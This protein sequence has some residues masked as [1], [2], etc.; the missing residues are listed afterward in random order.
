MWPSPGLDVDHDNLGSYHD[1]QGR[2][3]YPMLSFVPHG[4]HLPYNFT[5]P[6]PANVGISPLTQFYDTSFQESPTNDDSL[7]GKMVF[8]FRE[9]ELTWLLFRPQHTGKICFTRCLL[10]LFQSLPT[11]PMSSWN[12]RK[13]FRDDTGMGA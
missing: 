6:D 10:R 3:R 2:S 12:A 11:N 9:Y 13:S 4:T 7:P 8:I 1:T 5:H